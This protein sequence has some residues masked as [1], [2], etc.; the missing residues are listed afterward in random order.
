MRAWVRIGTGWLAIGSSPA[1]AQG[2][3]AVLVAAVGEIEPGLYALLTVVAYLVGFAALG[4][5][6]LRLLRSSRDGRRG[7]SAVG[8]VLSFAAAVVMFSFP[9]WL[10]SGGTSLLGRGAPTT[11]SY[12]GGGEAASY[13]ALLEA[14]WS[15]VEFVG[16]VAFLRGWLV[17]RA[18]ADGVGRA[19]MPSGVWHIVGGLLCWHIVPVLAAVQKTVGIELLR[20]S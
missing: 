10:E 6:L 11:L 13:N 18:A 16:V 5:G 2:F 7:P 19:T 9:S 20:A 14:L 3:D 8:T 15:I 1:Q 17:L 4:S 12:G